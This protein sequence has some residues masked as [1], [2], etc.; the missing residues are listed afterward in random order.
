MGLASN[1]LIFFLFISILI[2][3]IYEAIVRAEE[4]FLR[5]KFKADFD[6]YTKRV[7]RWLPNFSGFSETLKNHTFAWKRVIIKEYNSTYS[8]ST[9][10]LL[11]VGKVLYDNPE[12]YGAFG[13]HLPT[14]ITI[15]LVFTALY[16]FVRFL[17]KSQ[18]L[19]ED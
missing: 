3:F 15:F 8:G 14:L 6:S 18:R 2:I 10:G 19:R 5:N 12:R 7:N 17:K 11:I 16:L 1:S 13:E 4:N 9:L